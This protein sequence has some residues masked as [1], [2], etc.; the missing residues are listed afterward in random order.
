MDD[1]IQVQVRVK[2]PESEVEQTIY[3]KMVDGTEEFNGLISRWKEF[4]TSEELRGWHK[5]G[6]WGSGAKMEESDG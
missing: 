3:T 4:V 5:L 6:E 2:F 1:P